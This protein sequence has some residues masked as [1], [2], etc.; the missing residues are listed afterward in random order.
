MGVACMFEL[1]EAFEKLNMA[2]IPYQGVPLSK[3]GC[4]DTAV[5]IHKITEALKILDV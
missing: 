3:D 1:E 4:V 5:D 2:N